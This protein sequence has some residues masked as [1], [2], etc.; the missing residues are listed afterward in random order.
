[1]HF[2][3]L[4]LHSEYSLVDGIVRIKSLVKQAKILGLQAVAITDL[5]NIF[6]FI[7]F[8]KAAMDAKIK[9]IIGAEVFI[10]NKEDL[11]QPF[12][13]LLLCQ[14]NDGYLNLSKL[15]TKE[16]FNFNINENTHIWK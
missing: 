10:E 12:R 15:L 6:G 5:N 13:L 16:R 8:Y 4:H 1:M 7:K 9:P 2:T 3:H 11:T 14:N